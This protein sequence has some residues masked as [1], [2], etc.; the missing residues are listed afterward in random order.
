M[1]GP[2]VDI[3][4]QLGGRGGKMTVSRNDLRGEKKEKE[5]SMTSRF[6]QMIDID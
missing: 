3:E 5:D 4:F 6:Y 2:V 1:P